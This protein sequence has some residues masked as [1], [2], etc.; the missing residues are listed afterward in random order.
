MSDNVISL[1]SAGPI[2]AEQL[3]V[4]AGPHVRRRAIAALYRRR[5]DAMQKDVIEAALLARQ[6][7]LP[8]D[9]L[10]EVSAIVGDLSR[11]MAER[12]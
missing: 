1:F 5:L 7:E 2:P 8:I 12:A 6:L 3:A 11:R 10:M 4:S 9:E